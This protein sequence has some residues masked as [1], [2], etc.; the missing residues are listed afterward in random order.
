M[1]LKR[2]QAILAAAQ[3]HIAMRLAQENLGDKR[4]RVMQQKKDD[5]NRSSGRIPQSL[6]VSASAQ[7]YNNIEN[8]VEE[9]KIEI[10][11]HLQQHEQYQMNQLDQEMEPA[12]KPIQVHDQLNLNEEDSTILRQQ[13][14]KKKSFVHPQLTQAD[15]D[16]INERKRHMAEK[17]QEQN[18]LQQFANLEVNEVENHA[19]S[20]QQ[21]SHY[22][23]PNTIGNLNE[24]SDVESAR[25]L[26]EPI[27]ANYELNQ[28]VEEASKEDFTAE[29]T[30]H[31]EERSKSRVRKT[32]G[33]K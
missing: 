33:K 27:Q 2:K 11:T 8:D 6:R 19:R 1:K 16:A 9:E 15:I 23:G 20:Q 4:E 17:H 30:I 5:V 13:V 12:S 31:Q 28:I 7:R 26:S 22:S 29:K 25:E 32:R 21:K 24:Q 14:S 3:S 10:N 18:T